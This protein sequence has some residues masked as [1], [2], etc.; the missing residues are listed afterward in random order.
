M[1]AA[2]RLTDSTLR[3]GSHAIKHQFTVDQVRAVVRGLD[4]AGVE[5]IEVAHGDGLGGSSFNYGFSG[6]DEMELVRAAVDEA[7]NARIAVLLLPGIGVKDDLA[8]AADIGAS[9]A[10]IATHSTEA[11]ISH[12]HIALA[13]DL[14]METV[15]FLMLS[16]MVAPSELLEQAL[17]ME[18][19]GAD[20][21]YVVDSAG[22]MTVSDT[23][24]RITTLKNGLKCGVGLHAHNNLSLAV[25]NS[26]AAIGEGI[27]QVD[28]CL[29]GLGAG[30]GNCPTEI[31]VAACDKA[32]FETGINLTDLL[33]VA[34]DVVRPL[35]P[36]QGV[37]D[38]DGL[39]LGY[40]GVYGSF[41]LHAKRAAEVYD[42]ACDDIL[43]ELGRRGIVGGQEDM[44][45]DVAL[46]LRQATDDGDRSK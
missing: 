7:E 29:T 4:R 27:D 39:M 45:I 11:D 5:V 43:L 30:A 12:Q 40:A 19:Y 26:L 31:L 17:L 38:R 44:I 3:D 35:S 36:N 8:Q 28:G 46:E 25:A 18:S 20:A 6:I 23:M 22:A 9:V 21:V 14:G 42:V 37:I 10:R 33:D 16:H 2:F 13:K 15:G 41:L 34:T 32:G 24:E 1:T